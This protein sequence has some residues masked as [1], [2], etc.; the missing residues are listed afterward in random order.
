MDN[1]RFFKSKRMAEGVTQIIGPGQVYAYLVEGDSRALLL[2]TLCGIGNLADYCRELT[3]L[4]ITVAN[5]HGHPDHAGGNFL[6][7]EVF[8]HPADVDMMYEM[9]TVPERE[10]YV[11]MMQEKINEPM[12][13]GPAD[14]TQVR[15]IRCRSLQEGDSFD[16]GGR[17]LEVFEVPGHSLG[18][19]CLLDRANRQLFAGDCCNSNTILFTVPGMFTCTTVEEYLVSLHKLKKL[20]DDFDTFFVCHGDNPLDKSCIDDAIECCELIMAGTDDAEPGMFLGQH[21]C[22]YAKKRG[23]DNRRLDGRIGNIAYAKDQIYASRT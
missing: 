7:E 15:P 21:P 17:V 1:A 3:Q 20:Q 9:S 2:D 10:A 12:T 19:V 8:I 18:S 11:R 13:W 4:P 14:V 16:L 23:A 22:W 6:F 5:T